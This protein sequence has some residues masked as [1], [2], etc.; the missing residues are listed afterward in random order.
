MDNIVVSGLSKSDWLAARHP[1]IGGSE[2]G[3]V[4]GLNKYK[5]ARQLYEEKIGPV[6]VEI[7]ATPKMLAGTRQEPLIAQ[8]YTDL[9]GNT[10]SSDGL[11]R[12]HPD[13][14]FCS[15]SLDRVIADKGDGRG[16]GVLECKNTTSM[17]ASTW[18]QDVPLPYYCQTQWG[19]FVSG[20]KWGAICVQIDGWDI[21]ILP[22]ER[23]DDFIAMMLEAAKEFWHCVETRTPPEA[24]ADDVE[25]MTVEAGKQVQA[26]ENISALLSSLVTTK[27][28]I[29]ALEVTEEQLTDSLKLKIGNAEAVVDGDKVLVTYKLVSV[30]E[31]YRP[32]S[33]YRKLDIKKAKRG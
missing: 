21:R 3:A 8:A 13:Y 16:P 6:P 11:L 19:M 27:A 1:H 2:I 7:E 4:L 32:A 22:V 26:D 31:S 18:E 28:Q 10:V 24:V 14:P 15:V 25:K 17:F 20:F 9:T 33:S 5:T 12:I 30:K 23:D 29:K